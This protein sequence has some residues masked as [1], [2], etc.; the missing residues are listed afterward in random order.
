MAGFGVVKGF[1]K[2]YDHIVMDELCHN[3]LVEGAR[4]ST[5]NIHRFTHLDNKAAEE[6]LKDLR[7]KN[8]DVGIVVITEGMYSMD[9]D[10]TN[11]GE[12]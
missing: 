10:F 12:L 2:A 11:M 5:K 1:T 3:C 9:A 6:I 7:S 8:P 4:A